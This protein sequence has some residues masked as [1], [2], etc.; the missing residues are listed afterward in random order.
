MVPSVA[1]RKAQILTMGSE[2]VARQD[3]LPPPPPAAYLEETD[4]SK[5][6]AVTATLFSLAM[7][8]VVLRVYVRAVM[9]KSFG[10]DGMFLQPQRSGSH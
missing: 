4:G 6:M 10:L 8:T 3:A 2:L 7:V 9:R 5:L 1:G